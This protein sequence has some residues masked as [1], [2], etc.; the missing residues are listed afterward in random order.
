ML[1][2]PILSLD[3]ALSPNIIFLFYLLNSQTL[4]PFEGWCGAH[5][6]VQLFLQEGSLFHSV[7]ELISLPL[8]KVSGQLGAVLSMLRRDVL[9][10]TVLCGKWDPEESWG[11]HRD[12]TTKPP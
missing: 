7:S 3:V 1:L 8:G 2:L 4:C 10:H 5:F 9:L 6:C 11:A 12:H